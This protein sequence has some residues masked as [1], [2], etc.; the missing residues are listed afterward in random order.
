MMVVQILK[1]VFI[2]S[3][4]IV[5]KI[6]RKIKEL[7]RGEKESMKC[8]KIIVVSKEQ[9]DGKK[10]KI[11]ELQVIKE[12]KTLYIYIYILLVQFYTYLCV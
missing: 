3:D 6:I 9:R 2:F 10:K 12:Y 1:D 5:G 11:G 7:E 4:K 8:N